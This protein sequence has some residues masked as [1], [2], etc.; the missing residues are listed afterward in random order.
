MDYITNNCID[1]IF[2]LNNIDFIKAENEIDVYDKMI[3][4]Y[5]K[6]LNVLEGY[7]GED[8]D[9]FDIFQEGYYM[10]AKKDD[11]D[12]P[13]FGRIDDKT[14]KKESVIKSI[15]HLIPRLA[16]RLVNS[17]KKIFSSN[18][19]KNVHDNVAG[20][21]DMT[22]SERG[23]YVT[24]LK[25]TKA[26][27]EKEKKRH[28]KELAKQ[29]DKAQRNSKRVKSVVKASIA[30]A[31]GTLAYT[32][33]KAIGDAVSRGVKMGKDAVGNAISSKVNEITN[34]VGSTVSKSV[35]DMKEAVNARVEV[36]EKN[37][38]ELGDKLGVIFK[39]IGVIC[40]RIFD[41]IARFF[42][43]I[44]KMMP[45]TKKEEVNISE[46][47]LDFDAENNRIKLPI[48]LSKCKDWILICN[49]F[50]DKTSM[51]IDDTSIKSNKGNVYKDPDEKRRLLNSTFKGSSS[52]KG[53]ENKVK[54]AYDVMT[55][56]SSFPANEYEKVYN[57]LKP[58]LEQSIKSCQNV[59]NKIEK[60][61]REMKS[62]NDESS[63]STVGKAV[64]AVKNKVGDLKDPYY[65]LEEDVLRTTTTI[66]ENETAL[67][68]SID[69]INEWLT[70]NRLAADITK[71]AV[72]K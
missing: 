34:Q 32:N 7:E 24:A 19:S 64:S 37:V 10:E 35:N 5:D 47:D 9:S 63:Q 13:L 29:I 11:K 4:A 53:F 39:Q 27:D 65:K 69:V 41:S 60:R 42:K 17:I 56:P 59:T 33:R 26:K 58:A 6:A 12:Q 22:E 50:L 54:S 72:A 16:G 71:E 44:V 61:L 40:K 3:N 28:A 2:A 38:K 68:T 18:S 62:D 51:L 46:S 55:R 66:L 48:T 30:L 20:I 15:V 49:E 70:L 52:D 67:M 23:V 36:L 43:T 57:D 1:T 45:W 8:V 21:N 14:K 31:V 25:M